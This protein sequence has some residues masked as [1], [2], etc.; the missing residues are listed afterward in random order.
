MEKLMGN[1]SMLKKLWPVLKDEANDSAARARIIA[2]EHKMESYDFLL[3][4]HDKVSYAIEIV[5]I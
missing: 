2:I 1:Y 4:R 5:N 3:G